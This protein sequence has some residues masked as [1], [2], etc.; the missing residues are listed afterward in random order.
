MPMFLS[1]PPETCKGFDF[2]LFSGGIE[3][4][5]QHKIG[6]LDRFCIVTFLQQIDLPCL[7]ILP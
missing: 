4:E 5:N 7:S 1:I 6:Y 3:R 2:L